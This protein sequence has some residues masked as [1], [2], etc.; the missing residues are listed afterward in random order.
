MQG[1]CLCGAVRFE[2]RGAPIGVTI[3]HCRMC[4][5]RS[6]SPAITAEFEHGITFDGDV[7]W[8]ASCDRGARGFSPACGS[9][10]FFRLTQGDYI[11]VGAGFF[12]HP[13]AVPP[14]TPEIHVGAQPSYYAFAQGAP[15]LTGEEFLAR[16]ESGKP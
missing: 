8:F 12:G 6:G 2:G 11:N 7:T 14:I 9:A 4:A 13:A 5:R 15:R 16:L 10:L 3:C 1:G